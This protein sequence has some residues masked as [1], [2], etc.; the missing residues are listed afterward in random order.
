MPV[1][2]IAAEDL[3]DALVRGVTLIDVREAH[4]FEDGHV[5][6]AVLIPLGTVP[7]R[8]DEFRGVGTPYVICRS[9]GRSL[10]ACEYLAQNGVEAINVAGGMLAWFDLGEPVVQGSNG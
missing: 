5:A 6:G 7:A 10:N 8:I 1:A 9:G 2:E 3:R 4:E